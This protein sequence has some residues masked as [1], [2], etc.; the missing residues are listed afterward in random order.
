MKVIVYTDDGKSNFGDDLNRWI[1]TRLLGSSPEGDDDTYLLGIGTLISKSFLPRDKQYIVLGSGVGYDAP[2]DDFGGPSWNVLAVRGPLTARALGLP[3]EKAVIDAA[4]LLRLLPEC[5]PWPESQ[6]DGVVFMP[7]YSTLAEGNWEKV[8]ALAGVTFLNPFTESEILVQQIRR[9]RLVIADAMHAAIVADA[10]RVPWIPVVLSPISN[11]FKWLDWTQSLNLPYAPHYIGHSTLIESFQN[12]SYRYRGIRHYSSHRNVDRI[13]RG[14]RSAQRLRSWKHWRRLSYYTQFLTFRA[15]AR[16]A[17]S[18]LL[19]WLTERINKHYTY[20]AA[21]RLAKVATL[22]PCLSDEKLLTSK[23]GRLA[24]LLKQVAPSAAATGLG[25]MRGMEEKKERSRDAA[26][27]WRGPDCR[28]RDAT[29]EAS[30]AN[31]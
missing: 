8:C 21:R 2:P 24:E 10:L 3:A 4:V 29:R 22:Q 26:S 15:P 1:W 6:R 30:A 12:F 31:S 5:E 23:V 25:G 13:I 19:V 18:R 7:H 11:T 27:P 17:R 16:M 20:R 14:Y 9:A 28:L